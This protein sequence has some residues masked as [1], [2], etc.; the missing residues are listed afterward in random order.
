MALANYEKVV[1]LVPDRVSG[2]VFRGTIL[3]LLARPEE[4][5][6]SHGRGTLCARGDTSWAH[7]N[8]GL[9]RRAQERYEE[10]RKCFWAAL[11]I[12]PDYASAA[13][14][15]ADVETVLKRRRHLHLV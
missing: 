3:A 14:A 10:A 1:V 11:E 4:A 5:A 7:F 12:D 9:I 13:T 6:E 2:H 8:L 15:L